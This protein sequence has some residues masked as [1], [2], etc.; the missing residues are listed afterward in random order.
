M[1]AG[2]EGINKYFTRRQNTFAQYIATQ[3][4]MDL[5]ERSTQR[6]RVRVSWRWWE[7]SSLDLEGA[8]KRAVASA[9][10]SDEKESIGEEDIIPLE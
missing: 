7:K 3:L 4:I 2:F 6:P 1:E 8:K 9:A 10:D 5:C